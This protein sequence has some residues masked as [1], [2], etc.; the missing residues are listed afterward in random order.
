MRKTSTHTELRYKIICDVCNDSRCSKSCRICEKDVCSA[1]SILL[2]LDI[3]LQNPSFLSD[4]PDH[5]CKNCWGE[6]KKYRDSIQDI[7]NEAD[8]A[9]EELWKKW[10]RKMKL[11]L[12]G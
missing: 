12:K 4:Y 3:D 11:N 10:K 5:I 6:G 2:D 9:E 7:R 8:I 1:C